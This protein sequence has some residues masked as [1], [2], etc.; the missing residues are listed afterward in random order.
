[1]NKERETRDESLTGGPV[2]VSNGLRALLSL[3]KWVNNREL[4]NWRT[5]DK[6]RKKKKK[7]EANCYLII[8]QFYFSVLIFVVIR[9]LDFLTTYLT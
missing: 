7:W 6:E 8:F 4:D 3:T 1:M 9:N 2:F 5:S